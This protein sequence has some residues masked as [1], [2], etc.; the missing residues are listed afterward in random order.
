[1]WA[2]VMIQ[3]KKNIRNIIAFFGQRDDFI[4]KYPVMTWMTFRK[5]VSLVAVLLS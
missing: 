3:H 4:M 5:L 2:S 1:M